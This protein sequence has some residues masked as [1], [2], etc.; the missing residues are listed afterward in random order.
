MN[1]FYEKQLVEL[2]QKINTL[3]SQMKLQEEELK[4]EKNL[5]Y[6]RQTAE[7]PKEDG[8]KSSN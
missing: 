2:H 4:Y 5:N 1:V 6:R 3:E 7:L 8:V